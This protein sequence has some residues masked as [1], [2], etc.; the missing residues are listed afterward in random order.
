MLEMLEDR[1]APAAP[2]VAAVVPAA[3]PVFTPAIVSTAALSGQTNPALNNSNLIGATL[4]APLGAGTPA[5]AT[6]GTGGNT[7]GALG[8]TS[9]AALVAA[10]ATATSLN[11]LGPAATAVPP[12]ASAVPAQGAAVL[13]ARF[14]GGNGVP[15][16]SNTLALF[17]PGVAAFSVVTFMAPQ[18]QLP[19][20][21]GTF[22]V[23]GGDT[24]TSPAP[25][26]AA[27]ESGEVPPASPDAGPSLG[28]IPPQGQRGG[29]TAPQQRTAPG[30]GESGGGTDQPQQRPPSSQSAPDGFYPD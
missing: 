17:T 2:A 30:G 21:T 20:A 3:A 14:S 10:V 25:G 11:P 26:N 18:A 5:N 16:I 29:V 1:L 9:P 19:R 8:S 12:P 28:A 13:L 24:G 22:A 6:L 4:Q 23:G 27:P 7:N 15:V